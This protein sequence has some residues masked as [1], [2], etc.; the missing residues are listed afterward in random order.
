MRSAPTRAAAA[1]FL[2]LSLVSLLPGQNMAGL[3]ASVRA[4]VSS[5]RSVW[6]GPITLGTSVRKMVDGR[7]TCLEANVEQ[8]NNIKNRDP[9]L[10]LTVLN[11]DSDPS[12]TSQAGLRLVLRGTAQLQG[13]PLAA[14]A[15]KRAAA[16]WE[17]LIQS[18]LTVVID[19]DFGPTLFGKAFD[20]NVVGTTDAQVLGG[21]SLYPAVRASLISKAYTP[22]KQSLYDSLPLKAVPTD[23]EESEGLAASSATLRALELINPVADPGAELVS[24]GLPPAVALN[25]RFS[26]DFDS[27][28]GI[29]AN[30]LDFE[31]IAV[32]EIG[33]ILGFVSF[34]GQQELGPALEVQPSIWD[35]FRVRPDSIKGDFAT[36]KRVLSSG[37]EQSFY[38]GDAAVSLSTGR[39]DGTGG[40]GKQASHWKD[41]S[42]TGQY[43]G[44]MDP[45]IGPGEHHFVTDDDI[46]V[47]DAIG[48]QTMNM[49]EAPFLVP[50]ISGR[51]QTGGM[52]APPLGVGVVSHTQFSIPVPAGAT[53]LKIDLNGNQDVDLFAR[54]GQRVFIQGFKPESDYFSAT[55][56]GLETISITPASSPPLKRGIYY[57][58]VANF[59][60]GETIFTVTATV[61]AHSPSRPPAI[62]NVGAHLEGDVL[63]L[64][65]GAFD[66]DGDFTSAEVGI[67]D[68]SGRLLNQLPGFA[69]L[70][71]GSAQ[72]EGQLS[73]G[74]FGAMLSAMR[75]SIVLIDHAGNRSPD[76]TIDFSRPEPGGLTVMGAFFDGS[77]LVLN[78]RGP[79]ENPEVEINGH[80]VAPPRG[81]KVKGS[82]KLTIKG[83][84][85]QLGLQPG[86]NRIR[87]RNSRGWSNILVLST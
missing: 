36:T 63:D 82:G 84:A 81:I 35:L 6:L 55:D 72:L 48:Y 7:A 11:P 56:S 53:Q 54:F 19:V 41:D 4:E 42:L 38:A 24:F 67:L 51:P 34:V 39:P 68:G 47:L 27:A 8:V 31:A 5:S 12:H 76:A 25:S 22:A 3:F 64:S 16:R 9:N 50:L 10:P 66:L 44:I 62:F 65:Y 59:G 85:G 73:I 52:I 60:P 17:A 70:S 46:A 29:A 69:L 75:A 71:G 28:D 80:V 43:I 45:T 77:R 83:D 33:H 61:T 2:V 40:D 15:F 57:I 20:D 18:Q 37:G 78:T 79:V 30:A 74:G 86:A 13:F 58:A 14:E 32:H 21:N 26:F 87:V 49:A 1:S 23:S